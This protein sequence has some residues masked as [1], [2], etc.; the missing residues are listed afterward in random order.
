MLK[1]KKT[2]SCIILFI[3][4]KRAFNYISKNRLIKR[5][6]DM[7]LDKNLIKLTRLFLIDQKV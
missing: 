7:G 3:D 6:I 4:V 1:E 5:M 2:G